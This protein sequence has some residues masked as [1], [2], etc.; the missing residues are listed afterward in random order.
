[1]FKENVSK[2]EVVFGFVFGAVFYRQTRC[3]VPLDACCNHV[4][5]KSCKLSHTASFRNLN[6]ITMHVLKIKKIYIYK[7]WR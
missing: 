4:L 5:D 6:S 7:I 1:M 2:D 3:V